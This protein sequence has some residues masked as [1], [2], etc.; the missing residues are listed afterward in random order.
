MATIKLFNLFSLFFFNSF[1]LF[2]FF[3]LESF[4]FIGNWS[5]TAYLVKNID[6]CRGFGNQTI[7]LSFTLF[8]I[9]KRRFLLS[10]SLKGF[11][12][13]EMGLEFAELNISLFISWGDFIVFTFVIFSLNFSFSALFS[14]YFFYTLSPVFLSNTISLALS[15]LPQYFPV[16]FSQPIHF[17]LSL[18][19]FSLAFLFLSYYPSPTEPG[20]FFLISFILSPTPLSVLFIFCFFFLFSAMTIFL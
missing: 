17:C 12:W 7:F 16:C 15:F 9:R 18:F 11:P 13:W 19:F 8:S 10:L 5:S 4:F 6:G 20:Y 1:F 3:N 2:F 14:V